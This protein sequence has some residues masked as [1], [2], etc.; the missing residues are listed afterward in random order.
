M[1]RDHNRDLISDLKPL[2]S[3]CRCQLSNSGSLDEVNSSFISISN[4]VKYPLLGLKVYGQSLQEYSTE[5]TPISLDNV[6]DKGS[7]NIHLTGKNLLSYLGMPG[8]ANGVMY[9]CSNGEWTL[10]GTSTADTTVNFCDM[11][12][13]TGEYIINGAPMADN[14]VI[15]VVEK[16]TGVCV[17]TD[18]GRGVVFKADKPTTYEFLFIFSASVEFNNVVFRPMLQYKSTFVDGFEPPAL[19][20]I[21]ITSALPL[22]GL[23]VS[24]GGNYTDSNGQQWICDEL[25]Y[26]SNGIGKVIKRIGM[27]TLDG[28]DDEG[29]QRNNTSSSIGNKYR[30]I[31]SNN[32][33]GMYIDTSATSNSASRILSNRY[34]SVTAGNT[35]TGT[36]G[37]AVSHTAGYV[38]I[39][40]AA[41]AESELSDFLAYLAAN[42]ITIVYQLATP[43]E[44]ELTSGE[45]SVF[46]TTY[47]NDG[48]T[49]F[50]NDEC[51]EMS[52]S[53]CTSPT[54]SNEVLPIIKRLEAKIDSLHST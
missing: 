3:V 19:I 52:V 34:L 9:S 13:P 7:I 14:I 46:N 32:F 6:G 25:V 43:E 27:A 35:W 47:T 2:L 21:T 45:M 22:C 11:L 4:S 23:P 37:I 5:G 8:Y 10:S 41:Y 29:W 49:N 44:I 33:G 18:H 17:A 28:S 31:T 30:F 38:S 42:P 24:T 54:L 1:V 40:D 36:T 26:D 50:F 15:Q 48:V 51:A 39:Y 16:D 53:V 20:P 12:L